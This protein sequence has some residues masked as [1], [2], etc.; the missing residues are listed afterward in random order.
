MSHTPVAAGVALLHLVDEE[1]AV[2][3]QEHTVETAGV[4]KHRQDRQRTSFVLA[5]HTD[6]CWQSAHF[7]GTTLQWA[8]AQP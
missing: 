6:S 5:T 8:A 4:S 7:R 2:V 1:R 3:E